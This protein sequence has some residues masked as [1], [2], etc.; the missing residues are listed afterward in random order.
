MSEITNIISSTN[1]DNVRNMLS[2]H[3][4]FSAVRIRN[5]TPHEYR[6]VRK[7]SC[8]Y[9]LQG[10]FKWTEGTKNGIEWRDLPTIDERSASEIS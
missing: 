5:N 7:D 9:V 4:P 6:L 10:C 2:N 8:T 3:P 1:I